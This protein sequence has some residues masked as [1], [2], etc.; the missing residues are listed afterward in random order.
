MPKVRFAKSQKVVEVPMGANLFHTLNDMGIPVASS[1]GGEGVCVKCMVR[2]IE[3]KENLS[4]EGDLETDMKEIHDVPA[5]HRMSC[6]TQVLGD[7]TIDTD[8]W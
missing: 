3:G 6:Q 5:G 8:Y 4:P 1:C 2:V 7:I